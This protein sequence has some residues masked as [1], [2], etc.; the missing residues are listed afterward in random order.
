MIRIKRGNISSKRRKKNFNLAK[1]YQGSNSKLSK[2]IK[3]QI[4]QSFQFAYIGRKLKKRIF[5]Y[6][7]ISRINSITHTRQNNYSIFL[8]C[9]R[10]INIL[11]NRKILAFLAFY[12]LPTF[13]II[14][15]ISRLT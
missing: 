14:E 11:I 6:N 4:I 7:W 5:R 8:G 3:E 15:R 1:G 2:K 13:Y 9:L 12:D 10:N